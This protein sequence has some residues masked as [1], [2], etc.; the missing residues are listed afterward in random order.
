MQLRIEKQSQPKMRRLGTKA[1]KQKKIQR[2]KRCKDYFSGK[3]NKNK[4]SDSEENPEEQKGNQADGPSDNQLVDE[5][6][7]DT[8]ISSKKRDTEK[9]EDSEG[10]VCE[11]CQREFPIYFYQQEEII[12]HLYD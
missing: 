6:A 3:R 2:S 7:K 5:V 1:K 11:L 10:S 12:K 4:E 9:E 8:K